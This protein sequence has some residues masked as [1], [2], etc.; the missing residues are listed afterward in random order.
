MVVSNYLNNS[1]V[2]KLSKSASTF[3]STY[4]FWLNVLIERAMRLFVW[5]KTDDVPQREIEFPLMLGNPQGITGVIKYKN[6]PTPFY[7]QYAGEPTEYFDT[8]KSISIYSPIKSGIYKIGKDAAII[9]N[10]SLG[11][12]L[13][14]LAHH[15]AMLLA[16]CEVSLVNTLIN[17]RDSGGIPIASTRA[18]VKT[19][20]AYR[21]ALCNGRVMPIEDPAFSAIQFVGVDKNTVLSIKDLEETMRNILDDYYNAIGVRTG[22]DKKGN[23][24]TAEVSANDSMVLLNIDDMLDSRKRGAEFVNK[25]FGTNWSVKKSDLL[26]YLNTVEKEDIKD[27]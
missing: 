2:K 20:E 26:N 16:H 8:W 11:N 15:Y 14:P 3:S 4:S 17:G 6:K 24:I 18:Q 21:D 10:N 27:E 19:L 9:L 12:S 23:M 5:E 13:Y 7:A 1:N 22:Y 25:L